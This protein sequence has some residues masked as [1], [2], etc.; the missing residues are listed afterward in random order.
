[1]NKKLYDVTVPVEFMVTVRG[2]RAA[3]P[4]HAEA[5]AGVALMDILDMPDR[6]SF[7]VLCD[8][9]KLRVDA[10]TCDVSIEMDSS[11]VG[12]PEAAPHD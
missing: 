5:A 9:K 2:V 11:G 12:K 6:D 7:K 4:E 10:D 3:K 1:M 8:I